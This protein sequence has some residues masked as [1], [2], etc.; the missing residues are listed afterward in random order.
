MLRCLHPHSLFLT[1]WHAQWLSMPLDQCVEKSDLFREMQV[2]SCLQDCYKLTSYFSLFF[3]NLKIKE[4]DYN[5]LYQRKMERKKILSHHYLTV[6][7]CKLCLD[8]L[9]LSVTELHPVMNIL[10]YGVNIQNNN[11]E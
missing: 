7:V 8:I 11:S 5:E 10:R 9:L 6:C 4:L 2:K 1:S 3:I